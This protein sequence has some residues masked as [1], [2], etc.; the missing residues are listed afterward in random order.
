MFNLLWCSN[1]SV[2]HTTSIYSVTSIGGVQCGDKYFVSVPY[3][4]AVFAARYK[5]CIGSDAAQERLACRKIYNMCD[6]AE[7]KNAL[8]VS[9]GKLPANVS[10]VLE[11]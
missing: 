8:K 7:K 1:R 5:W 4:P 9:Q 10:K 3:L 2:P 6:I 11:V